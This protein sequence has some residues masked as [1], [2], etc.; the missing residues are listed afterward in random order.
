MRRR[1]LSTLVPAGLLAA[2][3]AAPADAETGHHS[4]H[5]HRHYGND[6]ITGSGVLATRT[7]DL[8]DFDRVRIDGVAEVEVKIGSRFSVEL[9]TD[10]NLID[11]VEIHVTDGELV[12]DQNDV[13]LDTDEGV[14]LAVEMPDLRAIRVDGVA[15]VNV[16]DLASDELSVEV[17]GVGN[18]TVSGTTGRL[19]IQVDG[20]GEL[21]L[22]DLVAQ[23]ADVSLDG[24][25]EVTV[26]VERVLS[27]QVD[28]MGTL[29]YRG[30]PDVVRESVDGFGEIVALGS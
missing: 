28:G 19:D 5:S 17:D 4:R 27:A 20:V 26:H 6:A 30:N 14:R 2:A 21:M 23:E 3:L 7:L 12:V 29:K 18:V 10:D 22:E 13:E 15:D 16:V 8:R 24:V 9:T 25:G 11:L 1:T